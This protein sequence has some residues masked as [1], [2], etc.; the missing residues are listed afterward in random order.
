MDQ[1]NQRKIFVQRKITV[2]KILFAVHHSGT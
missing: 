1:A 2:A